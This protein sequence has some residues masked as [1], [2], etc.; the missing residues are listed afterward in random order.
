MWLILINNYRSLF[1]RLSVYHTSKDLTAK[2]KK[3]VVCSF[4]TLYR[5]GNHYLDVFTKLFDM[6]IIPIL[7]YFHLAFYSTSQLNK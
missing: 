1:T 3:A 2:A 4:S 7:N 6:Q 5:I